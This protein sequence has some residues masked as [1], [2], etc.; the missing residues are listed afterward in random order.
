MTGQTVKIN[1]LSYYFAQTNQ[2][3]CQIPSLDCCCYSEARYQQVPFSHRALS[4]R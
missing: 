3:H 1:S 2:S 4:D